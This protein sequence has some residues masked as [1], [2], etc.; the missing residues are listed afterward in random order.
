MSDQLHLNAA[1]HLQRLEA[2]RQQLQRLHAQGVSLPAL[3][4]MSQR[5][6]E[7]VTRLLRGDW[8]A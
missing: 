8:R 5:S 6:V 2:E 7:S 1:V 3:A 4:R